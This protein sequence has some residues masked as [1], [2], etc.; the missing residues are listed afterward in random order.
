M[1]LFFDENLSPRLVGLVAADYPDSAH[2]RE[3]V[4][5]LLSAERDRVRKRPQ[6]LRLV[7]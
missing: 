6:E 5:Q 2:A 7:Y 4:A 1:K 3:V